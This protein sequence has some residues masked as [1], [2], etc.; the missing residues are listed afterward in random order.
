MS[1]YSLAH[2]VSTERGSRL[3]N[4]ILPTRKCGLGPGGRCCIL[5][6]VLTDCQSIVF[7]GHSALT[8]SRLVG[9]MQREKWSPGRRELSKQP[10]ITLSL[11]LHP[12]TE[13]W[14][15][16]DRETGCSSVSNSKL[17]VSDMRKLFC[18]PSLKTTISASLNI[19]SVSAKKTSS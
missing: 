11:V 17:W 12:N 18:R 9:K 7:D 13:R 8:A 5:C 10:P 14:G 3:A 4:G 1:P 6:S 16:S 15:V 2:P 19:G